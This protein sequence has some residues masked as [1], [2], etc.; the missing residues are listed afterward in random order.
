M[1]YLELTLAILKPNVA[2]NPVAIKFV[3]NLIITSNFKIVRSKRQKC[4]IKELQLFY[5]EH[6]DKFFYNRLITFMSSGPS[7]LFI[8][9]K[10]N[11]IQDWR[12]LLGPTKVYRTQFEEP[13]SLRGLFGQSDTRNAFHG[14][15]SKESAEREMSIFFP[16]FNISDWFVSEEQFF[17]NGE[18]KFQEDKFIHV[19]QHT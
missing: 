3:K 16:E 8:L 17:V 9:A 19:I 4:K 2:V 7:E 12:K 6:K 10:E 18:I 1:G 15:D 5:E 11:A 14:S 13:N